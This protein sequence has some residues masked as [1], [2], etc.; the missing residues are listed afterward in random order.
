MLV[1]GGL[2][3][4]VPIRVMRDLKSGPNIVAAFHVPAHQPFPV[5]YDELPSRGQL[6]RRLATAKDR[7]QLG[8]VPMIG[9]VLAR[10]LMAQS[11]K[12]DPHLGPDD[13]LMVP[14]LPPEIGLL[15]WHRHGELKSDAYQ[16]TA[17][18]VVRLQG[19]QDLALA[20][21]IGLEG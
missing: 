12:F 10:A 7:K 3:D 14:P 5:K 1:D 20:Q 6:L 18:E 17:A 11:Q 19:Q 13:I 9:A 8:E 4:N 21:M 2:V 16:W 15:D